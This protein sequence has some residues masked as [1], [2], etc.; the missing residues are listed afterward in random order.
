MLLLKML[1][2][3]GGINSL[4]ELKNSDKI[5]TDT[6]EIVD[7]K[8]P[9]LIH[10]TVRWGCCNSTQDRIVNLKYNPKEIKGK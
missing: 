10:H 5:I 7:Q 8:I 2:S 4:T 6:T 9:Y 3:S 1:Q